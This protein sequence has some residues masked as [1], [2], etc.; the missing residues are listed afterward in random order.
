MV[1]DPAYGA[2]GGGGDAGRVNLDSVS[3]LVELKDIVS[4]PAKKV[5]AALASLGEDVK[6]FAKA[7]A[8][9]PFHLVGQ[10]LHLIFN[11]MTAIAGLLTGAVGG[12]LTIRSIIETGRELEAS[13]NRIANIT[14][15]VAFGQG[16][17]QWVREMGSRLPAT[18][19]DL[20]G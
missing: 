11:K 1:D 14:G 7:A 8:A 2:Y 9:Y 3:I 6:N 5:K 12:F 19:R 10:G 20:E 13:I 4:G 17:I 16:M 18:E 15:S